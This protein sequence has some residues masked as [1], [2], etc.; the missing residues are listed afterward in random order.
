MTLSGTKPTHSLLPH[1]WNE[2]Q[3][4]CN[5]MEAYLNRMKHYLD[6]IAV[7]DLPNIDAARNILLSLEEV[8]QALDVVNDSKERLN[9][10]QFDY[11]PQKYG[12]D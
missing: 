1:D 9:A 12:H 3:K 6:R 7:S 4:D 2:L 8:A 5:R 10:M 11:D